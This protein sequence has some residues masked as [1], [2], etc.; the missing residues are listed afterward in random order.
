MNLIPR[1]SEIEYIPDPQM[2]CDFCGET[3]SVMNFYTIGLCKDCDKCMKV[4]GKRMRKFNQ[5]LRP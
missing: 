5:L 1:S 3:K 2:K 4:E